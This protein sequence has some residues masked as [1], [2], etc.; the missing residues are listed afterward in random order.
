[1]RA[2]G[3]VILASMTACTGTVQP[4]GITEPIRVHRGAFRLGDMPGADD[5]EAPGPEVTSLELSST[6]L[7]IGQLDRF[8]GGRVTEDTFSI[9]VAFSDLGSG[10]WVRPVEARDPA[11]PGERFFTIDYDVGGGIPAGLHTLRFVALDEAGIAGPFRDLEVCVVDDTV[12]DNLNACDPT[13]SP[14]AAVITLSWDEAVDLD[15]VLDTPDGKRVD[16]RHPSTAT[17][18][19]PGAPISRE[20][21]ADPHVGR[22][23]RNS[24]AECELDA[25]N[26]ESIGWQDA[27]AE[28]TYLVYANLYDACGR[29][30]ATFSV[31]VYRSEPTEDGGEHLVLSE[32]VDGVV[33]GLS[34]NGGAGTPL[35]LTAVSFP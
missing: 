23:G 20:V 7:T 31:S 27:P 35:Y 28:G 13:S 14:P 5:P 15:L 21:L 9:G 18:T 16:H 6:I 33:L 29:P 34:A 22:L 3:L 4:V 1:M 19:E 32:R 10:W 11:F 24:N 25:R 26:A 8:V 2:L 30:S 12:P 17:P